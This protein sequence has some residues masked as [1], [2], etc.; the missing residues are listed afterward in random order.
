MQFIFALFENL[1]SVYK[2]S[3]INR[4]SDLV[5]ECFSMMFSKQNGLG[6]PEQVAFLP[7]EASIIFTN[8]PFPGILS[9]LEAIVHESGLVQM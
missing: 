6:F 4:I 5:K 9:P 7:E 8:A 1:I 2:L 3:P